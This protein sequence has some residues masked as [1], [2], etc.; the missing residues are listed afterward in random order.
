MSVCNVDLYS[1]PHWCEKLKT[2]RDDNL[3]KF[4]N[5]FDEVWYAVMLLSLVGVMNLELILS[6]LISI[7]G[8][9]PYFCLNMFR[10]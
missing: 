5:D 8:R 10:N 1:R 6:H 2:F 7:Q 3:L 4:S 9:K